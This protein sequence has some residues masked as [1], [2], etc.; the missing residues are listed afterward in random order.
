LPPQQPRRITWFDDTDPRASRVR[1][2]ELLLWA[3][4]SPAQCAK[5]YLPWLS[6][7][8]GSSER[9]MAEALGN[10]ALE[11]FGKITW[12]TALTIARTDEAT[13][14]AHIKRGRR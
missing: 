1:A 14:A 7:P 6:W 11:Q 9:V 10:Y 8:A 2:E 5:R 4:L 13:R 3:E 12:D